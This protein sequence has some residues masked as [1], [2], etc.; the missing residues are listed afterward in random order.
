MKASSS[1]I[2]HISLLQPISI[3][4]YTFSP[5]TLNIFPFRNDTLHR[6][7]LYKFYFG[8][9]KLKFSDLYL[10]L[11]TASITCKT[12]G[13][14]QEVDENCDLTGY[15]AVSRGNFLDMFRYNLSAPLQGPNKGQKTIED[16]TYKL[17]RNVWNKCSTKE[18]KTFEDGSNRLSRKVG[19]ILPLRVERHL[20]R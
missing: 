1:V 17:S 13:F 11:G 9:K 3:D 20:K 10:S 16:G 6:M 12:S 4:L 19:K 15:Y 2:F 7:I 18:Q 5:D 14:R 8:F